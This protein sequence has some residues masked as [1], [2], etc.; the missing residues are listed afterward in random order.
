MPNILVV[1]ATRGLGASIVKTYAADPNN[2]ICATARTSNPPANTK[3]VAYIPS[4]D[5]ATAEA[6]GT[7]VKFLESRKIKKL[8]VVYITAGYFATESLK[9]IGS[10]LTLRLVDSH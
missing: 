5:I 4:I 6:S 9:G 7:L 3:N 8:D 1:G 10:S 2:H